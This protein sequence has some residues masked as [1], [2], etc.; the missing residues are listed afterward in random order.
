MQMYMKKQTFIFMIVFAIVLTMAVFSFTNVATAEEIQLVYPNEGYLQAEN[1]DAIGVND[2]FIVTADN[3]NKIISYTGDGSGNLSFADTN[4]SALKIFVFGQ[5]AIIKGEKAF[6]ILSTTDNTLSTVDSAVINADSYLAT[7]GTLLYVHQYGK[8]SVYGEDLTAPQNVYEDSIFNNKPVLVVSGTMIYGFVVEHGVSRVYTYD[9]ATSV[10][11][12]LIKDTVVKSAYAGST[13]FGFDGEN[14][15]LIDKENISHDDGTLDYF[16]TDLTATNFT[17]FG[18][19]LYIAKGGEGYDQYAYADGAL[20][21]VSNHSYTGDGLDRL[22]NPHGVVSAGGELVIADTLNNRLLY[23]GAS[24]ASVEIESPTA[25]AEGNGKVYVVTSGEIA[26]VENKTIVGKIKTDLVVKDIVYSDGMYVLAQDGV[27]MNIIGSLHK[28]FDV[29][30]GKALFVRELNYIL[31][32]TGV[33]VARSTS[34]GLEK[35][36]LL[37]FDIEGY[38]PIDVASDLEGNVY[39]LGDD[40]ALHFYKWAD[41]ISS[42]IEGDVLT[43]TDILLESDTYNFTMKSMSIIG[44]RIV[45]ATDENAL[46]SVS[47]PMT[48][49]RSN[50]SSID[51][52]NASVGTYVSTEKTYFMSNDNDGTTAVAVGAGK[53]FVCYESQGLLYTSF[54]GVKGFV[55]CVDPVVADT[56]FAGEYVAKNDIKLYVNPMTDGGVTVA[57]GTALTVIDDGG[58]S[59]GTWVRVEYNGKTYYTE[60]SGLEKKSSSKPAPQPEKPEKPEK[61]NKDYGRAKA[62]RAG[63][64]VNLYSAQDN[65]VVVAQV[66][67]GTKLEVVEKIGD[68]YKVKYEGADVLIHKDQFK[69]DGLTTV[70]IIAIVLS[71]VVVLAGGLIFMVTSLSKKKEEKQQN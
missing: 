45:I 6:Y 3:T 67:D 16:E 33:V 52:D 42:N 15:I 66:T 20:T 7:D 57:K 40:N 11:Q 25:I 39:V 23:V 8:V 29:N 68:F 59:D 51:T 46:V 55:F 24:V 1:V 48:N 65:N 22:N 63:E 30:D 4:D 36:N 27:Y 61:V 26:I 41:V 18:D 70:Q 43:S 58:Y 54:E 35:N 19:Y 9:T 17:A 13:I 60:M 64:L 10:A 5:S 53:A 37:S 47:N 38:T 71:V 32:G 49:H 34:S 14:I 2:A 21:F 31:S 28:V 69:L 56:S 44:D 12:N 62:S 50:P